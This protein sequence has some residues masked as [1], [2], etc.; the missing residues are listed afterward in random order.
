MPKYIV[1]LTG[2]VAVLFAVTV[3]AQTPQQV[4][5]CRAQGKKS[6]EQV[7]QLMQQ[8]GASGSIS[9]DQAEDISRRINAIT[10]YV[11]SCE[12]IAQRVAAAPAADPRLAQCRTQNQRAL[13]EAAQL[14]QK[15]LSSGNLFPADE[16]V[17]KSQERHLGVIA[18]NLNRDSLSIEQCSQHTGDIAG[19]RNRTQAIADGY[20]RLAQCRERNEKAIEE[21]DQLA[22]KVRS[23]G[24]ILPIHEQTLKNEENRFNSYKQNLNREN[25]NMEQCQQLSG[26]INQAIANMRSSTQQMVNFYSQLA[27][28]REQNQKAIEEVAQLVQKT[29]SSGNL[30]P[31]QVQALKNH[32]N[33]LE[34]YKKELDRGSLTLDQCRSYSSNISGVRSGVQSIASAQQVAPCRAENEEALE[35]ANQLVQKAR[36]SGR[37]TQTLSQYGNR[38]NYLVQVN[39]GS[40]LNLQQCQQL[41]REVDSINT[42]INR[43][44]IQ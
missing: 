29:A 42:N 12:Q 37:M 27:Q 5:Q 23:Y 3:W 21:S 41:A 43:M 16:Q 38:I 40:N 4:E 18:Q 30:P 32:E 2:I 25:L 24:N 14:V 31:S 20:V 26:A 33:R 34:A 22:Q 36:T 6:W 9:P 10:Q 11:K 13:E 35:K 19:I 28:C 17:L 39:K 8:I 7:A 15:T 44:G 1:R